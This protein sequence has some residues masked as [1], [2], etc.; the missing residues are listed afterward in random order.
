MAKMNNLK[1]TSS[2]NSSKWIHLLAGI[3]CG[4]LFFASF[5]LLLV[6]NFF[7]TGISIRTVVAIGVVMGFSIIANQQV[8]LFNRSSMI[9]HS[10]KATNK[11]LSGLPDSYSVFN[12]VC[13]NEAQIDHVVVGSNGVFVVMNRS[14][15]GVIHCDENT[16]TWEIEKKGRNGGNYTSQMGN[17]VKKLKWQIHTLSKYLKDNECSVWVDGC[18]YFSN[19]D[20]D[21]LNAPSDCFDSDREVV[22]FIINYVPKKRINPKLINKVKD[23]LEV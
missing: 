10:Y 2:I 5:F 13:I 8:N 15:R 3:I 18:V 11:V 23:L 16:K 1:E 12:N 6:P 22:E 20:S 17:P 14:V 9:E 19:F 21:L 4:I 7:A